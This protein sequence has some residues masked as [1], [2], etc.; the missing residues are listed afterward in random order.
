MNGFYFCGSGGFGRIFVV[1]DTAK[2]PDVKRCLKTIK[3]GAGDVDRHVTAQREIAILEQLP[4]H[5][6]VVRCLG[7][8]KVVKKDA[9]GVEYLLLL[10]LCNGVYLPSMITPLL[11]LCWNM[12]D[13]TSACELVP[14]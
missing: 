12:C 1:Q 4:P 6:C 13:L 11:C 14:C 8:S 3:A 9:D 7:C 10:E 2:E 5:S